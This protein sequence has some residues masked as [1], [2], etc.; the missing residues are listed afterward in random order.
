MKLNIGCVHKSQPYFYNDKLEEGSE[1]AE[2]L[3]KN[4]IMAYFQKN[5]QKTFGCCL[6]TKLCIRSFL[7]FKA[8]NVCHPMKVIK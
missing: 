6:F 3:E 2:G 1:I 5:Q 8:L 4:L 7:R